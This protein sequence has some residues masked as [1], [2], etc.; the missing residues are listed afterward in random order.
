MNALHPGFV[1]SNFGGDAG[2]LMGVLFGVAK[3]LG[4]LGIEY[5][6]TGSMAS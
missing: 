3:K 6:T 5:M 4:A 1:A 2:G